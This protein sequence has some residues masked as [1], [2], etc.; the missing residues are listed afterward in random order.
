MGKKAD[1]PLRKHT[2]NLFDG[3]WEELQ[4]IFGRDVDVSKVIREVVHDLVKKL[5]SKDP[6][7]PKINIE[8]KP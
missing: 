3:D 2:L 6:S 8:V 4:D 7:A 1:G 5:K